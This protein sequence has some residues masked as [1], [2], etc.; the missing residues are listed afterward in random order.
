MSR[1]CPSCVR[2]G[3]HGEAPAV[4]DHPGVCD[5]CGRA[6]AREEHQLRMAAALRSV[7]PAYRWCRIGSPLLAE[8]VPGWEDHALR[9]GRMPLGVARSVVYTGPRGSGKTTLATCLLHSMIDNSFAGTERG[10][11]AAE[12]ARFVSVSDIAPAPPLSNAR[13]ACANRIMQ[14]CEAWPILLLDD[15]GEEPDYGGAR[16]AQVLMR[17][18]A[19]GLRTYITTAFG[20]E[21]W[22]SWYGGVA[23][24]Y[25]DMPDALVHNM[26][27]AA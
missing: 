27:E 12:G 5:A 3:R 2:D 25:F 19:L 23:R 15:V 22:Q 14:Q 21:E 13:A 9:L 7:P 11:I 26:G 17:R 4:V 18:H 24:R 1:P 6:Q 20:R 10:L 16:V 8:R